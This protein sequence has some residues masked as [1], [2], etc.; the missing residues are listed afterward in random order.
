VTLPAVT[1]MVSDGAEETFS[2]LG[3]VVDGLSPKVA[4][5]YPAAGLNVA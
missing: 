4:Q 2:D 5:R 1:V 3:R